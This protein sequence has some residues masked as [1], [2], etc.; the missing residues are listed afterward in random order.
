MSYCVYKHTFPN[1][2]V[3]I[4]IT[5]MKPEHRWKKNGKGYLEKKN[6]NYCQP[7]MAYAVLKYG[8]K[9]VKHEILFENLTKE[10]AEQKEIELISY[11]KSN[12]KEYGYN[13]SNGGNCIGTHSD[14][15]K[16][17]MSKSRKG[18]IFSEEHKKK[19]SEANRKR[20]TPELSKA[21]GEKVREKA[22]GRKAAKE[23]KD[24]MAKAHS[25]AVRCIET[26]VIYCSAVEA[27]EQTH[28]N[29]SSIGKCCRKEKSTAGG[30]H[31]EF[32]E[33]N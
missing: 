24:K 8:W 11:Y 30:Y 13:I 2:K 31:W 5:C 32:V 33:R 23:T 15:S 19:I 20:W 25:K 18:R 4:G 26:N 12:Q 9:N 3:Y 6:D 14:E 28:I 21:V 10:E 1:G 29:R 17:K 16:K 7:L 22:K 27:Y